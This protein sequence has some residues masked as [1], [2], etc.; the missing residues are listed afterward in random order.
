MTMLLSGTLLSLTLM[1]VSPGAPPQRNP[2]RGATQAQAQ[3]TPKPPPQPGAFE[4]PPDEAG[5]PSAPPAGAQQVNPKKPSCEEARRRNKGVEVYFDKVELEKL[6]QTVSDIT[7]KTFIVGDNVKGKISIIGPES[8]RVKVSPDEFYQAFLSA[9]DAN[10]LSV[11]P[12]GRFMKIVEKRTAKQGTIPTLVNPEDEFAARDQMVTKLLK[13]RYADLE[14]L[15]GVLQQLVSK[16]GDTLPFQP[17]TIIINDVASN[18][19]RLERIADQLD[20]RASSDEIRVVQVHYASAPDIADKIQKLFEAKSQRPGGRPGSVPAPPSA[21]G[22]PPGQPA[23]S[24]TT[25]ARSSAGPATLSQVITDERTNQLIIIATPAAFERIQDLIAALD[26]PTSGE[27]RVN[28]YYLENANA[29]DIATTLQGLTQSSSGGGGR[30][31]RGPQIPNIPGAARTTSTR[32][33]SAEL[34]SGEV[35]V[36]ADK[37]SNSLVIVA[38]QADYKNLIK[39]IEKLDRP[40]RQVFVEAV[41]MEVNVN[42]DSELGLNLHG[43]YSLNT[44]AGALPL[45][46]ATKYDKAPGLPPSLSIAS[47]ANFGGFLAGLQG[48]LIPAASS[49]L[50]IS[51][52]AFG[53]VL[54][55]LQTSSDVNVLSTPHILTSDNEEATITVG[56]NVPFQAGFAPSNLGSLGALGANTAAAGQLGASG[57]LGSLLG[58]LQS[59]F[60]PITRQ[61]VELKLSVKPQINESDYIRLTIDESTEEIASKDQVLGPTTSK[62]SAKTTVVAKDQETVV[63][64]G[65]M[66]DRTIESVSKVPILGDIPILG[67][68]FRDQSRSKVKTN[69]LLFLTP[70]IIRDQRDFSRILERKIKERQQFIEQF[71][72]QVPGYEVAID[73]SRKAGPWAKMNQAVLREQ[74]R[75]EGNLPGEKVIRPGEPLPD[76]SPVNPTHPGSEAA[77][78]TTQPVNPEFPPP[79]QGQPI[80]GEAGPEVVEPPAVPPSMQNPPPP[81]PPPQGAEFPVPPDGQGD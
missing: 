3:E 17:D 65:I 23:T 67:H 40:R 8:G 6:L 45:L 75:T 49:G 56:Q 48:P 41:I 20:R 34:F 7:C 11:V 51:I 13:V 16:D 61:N 63:L 24:A 43:G 57:Q 54:H 28:V 26:R 64:G 60:A 2:R 72:G 81:S 33:T 25:G 9:L 79:A 53:V 18:V 35:K 77:P 66:Q 44:G 68:L 39:V 46:F 38:S 59:Q 80:P 73:F 12:M 52:P 71:Y 5:A 21:G 69:L 74:Q 31:G 78:Q 37:S 19:Q 1:A 62:R 29:E 55:A 30:P 58:G 76:H 32:S 50:G 22:V 14:Q 27:G 47:L 42:R 4:E 15:R 10:G 70:Y 36:S